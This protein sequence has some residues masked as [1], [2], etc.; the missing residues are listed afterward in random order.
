MGNR[1]NQRAIWDKY[2]INKMKDIKKKHKKIR[3]N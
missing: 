3:L 1:S 2:S